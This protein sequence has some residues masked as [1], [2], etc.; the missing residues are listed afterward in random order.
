[1]YVP[2]TKSLIWYGCSLLILIIYALISN[3]RGSLTYVQQNMLISSSIL[4]PIL[5]WY[6]LGKLTNDSIL[7]EKIAVA[8]FLYINWYYWTYVISNNVN[9][10][11]GSI[12]NF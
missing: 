7:F 1:M 2:Y 10:I 3:A 5:F 12:N 4:F 9:S 6:L 11:Y 8:L